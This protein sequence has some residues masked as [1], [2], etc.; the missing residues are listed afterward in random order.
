MPKL[1]TRGDDSFS[2]LGSVETV[3]GG[4]RQDLEVW[5]T[6][7]R[8]EVRL[9]T[10]RKMIKCAEQDKKPH[11]SCRATGTRKR[12]DGRRTLDSAGAL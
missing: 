9:H 10:N 3:H 7:S 6:K 8:E 12:I 2:V 11:R 1:G 4:A 5:T